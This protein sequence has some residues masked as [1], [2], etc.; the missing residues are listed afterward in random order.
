MIEGI[1][2]E[3]LKEYVKIFLHEY[4]AFLSKEQLEILRNIN[5][6]TIISLDKVDNPLGDICYGKIS[7]SEDMNSFFDNLKTMKEYNSKKYF[8][9]NKNLSSYLE[10]MCHNGYSVLEYYQDILMYFVFYLVIKNKS[11]FYNGLINQE[12]KYLSIK[13]HLRFVNLYAKEEML[14]EKITPIFKIDGMRK[15]L[16]M[17]KTNCFKYISDY[18]GF[19]YAKMVEEINSLMEDK[20]EMIKKKDY[21]GIKGFLDYIDDYDSII[22]GDVYNYL[23]DFEIENKIKIS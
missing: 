16:F 4:E 22:Y 8:L 19:R 5:Y 20:Q 15:I 14:V 3:K 17:D 18:F 6:E 11:S 10:Y 2:R 9:N 23:L 1:L 12:I 21:Q 7:L 13:Y